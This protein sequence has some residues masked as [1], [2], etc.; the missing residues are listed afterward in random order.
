M[1][2]Q[3]YN[4]TTYLQPHLIL[5]NVQVSKVAR[6][7][8]AERT[9]WTITNGMQA[10]GGV[11]ITVLMI[12]KLWEEIRYV[13]SLRQELPKGP[14]A[15]LS[16]G[17][18]LRGP[19][20]SKDSRAPPT[21]SDGLTVLSG[22]INNTSST[23][24]DAIAGLSTVKRML[25]EATVW[26]LLAPQ[27]FTGIRAPPRGILLFG[28]P[29]T[30]KT[31]L[32]RAVAAESQASFF[33]I[34][35]SNILSMWYGQSEA[36][37]KAL[38]EKARQQQPAVIF[39]DEVDSL[40][41]KRDGGHAGPASTPD[42]RLVNE[43]LSWIDGIQSQGAG[44]APDAVRIIIIA[45]T[46]NPWDLDEA[47]LSRF[48]RRVYVPMPDRDARAQLLSRAVASVTTSL[49]PDDYVTLADKAS[50]YS[51]RDLTEVCRE[52][53]MMPLRELCGGAL[54]ASNAV[55]STSAVQVRNCFT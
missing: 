2:L 11:F 27:M 5:S 12:H 7:R 32:G 6:P 30:G 38:F 36:N 37:V 16:D 3:F 49:S 31:M 53:A 23:S 52:A 50:N 26:P 15:S 20:G 43:F 22:I 17:D 13:R 33:S 54:L 48:A 1:L 45:A 19:N 41:G 25:Q 46:N 9:L 42:R 34:T 24:W 55:S 10:V 35:C 8:P 18:A 51:G 14:G 44:K 29:G 40:L 28:P 21:T 4:A 39:I 47:A